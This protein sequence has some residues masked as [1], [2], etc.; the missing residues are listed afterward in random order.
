[1]APPMRKVREMMRLTLMPISDAAAWSSATA[2]MAL[3]TLVRFTSV[4]R[5]QSISSAATITTSDLTDTS[6]VSVSSK[7]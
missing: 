2:R 7:R 6:M 5:P 1:M 4:Y 3:P